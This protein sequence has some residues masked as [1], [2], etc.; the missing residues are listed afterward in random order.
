VKWDERRIA[1]IRWQIKEFE[2]VSSTQDVARKLATKGEPEGTVIIA[3]HQSAGRGRE[4]RSWFS[5]RGAGIWATCILRPQISPDRLTLLPI[6]V[7]NSIASAIEI[8]VEKKTSIKWPNDVYMGSRKLAGVLCEA[9]SSSKNG[10]TFVLTG[11]GVN[12]QKPEGDFPEE[13]QGIATSVEAETGQRLEHS[14]ILNSILEQMADGY[15]ALQKGGWSRIVEEASHR[16]MLRDRYVK[17]KIGKRVVE[18]R[19]TGIGENGGLIL[20]EESGELT[21]LISGEVIEFA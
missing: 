17:V 18:G 15:Q 10:T 11:F 8:A 14:S 1:L 13:L 16:D 6:L 7:S 20:E 9:E 5:P 3:R 2:S 4:G 19:S 21:E 12:L